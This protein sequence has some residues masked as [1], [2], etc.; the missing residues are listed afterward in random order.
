MV[1]LREITRENYITC[2]RLKVKSEQESFVASN[3]IS[4]A[5][6]KYEPECIPLAIYDDEVMVGFTMYCVD[7]EVNTYYIYRLMIDEKYQSKGYGH[8]S[9]KLLLKKIKAD[10]NYNRIYIDCRPE[11][12][13]AQR[14]YAELG[15][16]PTDDINDGDDIY[17][18]YDY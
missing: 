5:Q 1:N 3:A 16:V 10:P 18:R 14:L 6:S 17:M 15:F 4:L 9:M 11:N 13:A 2:L 7:T 8:E 12:I